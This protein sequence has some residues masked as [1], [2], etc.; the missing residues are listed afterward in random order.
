MRTPAPVRRSWGYRS[1]YGFGNNPIWIIIG[2]N[3]LMF[4]ATLIAPKLILLLGLQ[5]AGFLD[6]PWTIV[7]NMFIHAGFWHLFGNM[8]TLFFF[9]RALIM[10]VGQNRFLLV[11][12]FGGIL[13][14]IFYL[15]IA[16]FTPLGEPLSIAV[17]ASG[18]VYAVAGALVMLR[19]NIRV[20]LYLIVTPLYGPY[21][22]APVT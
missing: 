18:A 10:L 1:Y 11:Y 13:G 4:V 6:R 2:A 15:V 17:G 9:G 19:P 12:F 7:T 5:P 14:N 21:L 3:F 20:L 22:Q 8:V 16:L